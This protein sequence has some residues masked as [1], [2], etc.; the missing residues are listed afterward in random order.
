[1]TEDGGIMEQ[2]T[3]SLTGTGLRSD[4]ELTVFSCQSP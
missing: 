1:V 3:L 4:G 2:L